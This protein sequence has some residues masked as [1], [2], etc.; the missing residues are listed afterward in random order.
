LFI[1]QEQHFKNLHSKNKKGKVSKENQSK[2]DSKIKNFSRVTKNERSYL[3]SLS[4]LIPTHSVVCNLN[5]H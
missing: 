2:H 3:F 1:H 4:P 5:S